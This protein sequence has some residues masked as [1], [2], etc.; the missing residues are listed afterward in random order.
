MF[1]V[2]TKYMFTFHSRSKTLIIHLKSLGRM[3][4]KTFALLV[5]LFFCAG[6]VFSQPVQGSVLIGGTAGFNSSSF[7]ETNFSTIH[8][9]PLLGFFLTDQL[10]VGVSVN[11][12]AFGGD[13]D[14]STFGI[15]P[16]VRYYFN[17]SG[18]ARFF[19]QAGIS[20]VSTDPG[21]PLDSFSSFGF[22]VGAGADWFLNPNV[23]LEAILGFSSSKAED[24]DESTTTIGLNIGVAAFIGN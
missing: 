7:D 3:K 19:G 6:A 20:Y 2:Y 16:F 12:T 23:A 13:S 11:L 21:E 5:S 10:A 14:G 15:G 18:E 22:G 17:N 24:A 9:N 8:L 1:F 4:H